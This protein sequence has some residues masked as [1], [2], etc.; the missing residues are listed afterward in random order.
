MRT[1]LFTLHAAFEVQYTELFTAIGKI[2]ERI[3]ALGSFA[4]G[5]ISR[6]SIV[7]GFEQIAENASEDDMIANLS[8]H[9]R[10]LVANLSKARDLAGKKGDNKTEG[11]M[12]TRIQIHEKH[13][14]MLDSF[15]A[16]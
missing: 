9:N 14:W 2:G 15:L 7:A 4:P 13:I 8:K 3:R 5:G 11:L 12:T 1:R 6:L 16:S 10:K